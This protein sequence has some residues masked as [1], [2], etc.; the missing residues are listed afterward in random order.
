MSKELK[1]VWKCSECGHESEEW[2]DFVSYDENKNQTARC[3]SCNE[4]LEG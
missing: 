2:Y 1:R 3:P 4:V